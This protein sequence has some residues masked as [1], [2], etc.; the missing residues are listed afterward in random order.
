[1]EDKISKVKM[2]NIAQAPLKLRLV[3]DLVRDKDVEK[4]LEILE[5]TNKKGAHFVKKAINSGIANAREQ[6]G[7]DKGDLRIKQILVNE[8]PTLKRGRFSARGRYSVIFKRRSHINL[9]LEVK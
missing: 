1:M 2:R 6:Y 5:F 7:V 4:A 9:E 8:A 3:A